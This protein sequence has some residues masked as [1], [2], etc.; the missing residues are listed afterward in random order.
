MSTRRRDSLVART[1]LYPGQRGNARGAKQLPSD[2]EGLGHVE[3][4][5]RDL[6]A[7]RIRAE[8][9][10]RDRRAQAARVREMSRLEGLVPAVQRMVPLRAQALVPAP[11]KKICE[12]GSL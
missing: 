11:T 7:G 5:H 8:R 2:G 12:F 6:Q 1:D 3:D 9:P 10:R 4:G